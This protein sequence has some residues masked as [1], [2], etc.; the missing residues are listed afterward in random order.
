MRQYTVWRASER[1]VESLITSERAVTTDRCTFAVYVGGRS[2]LDEVNVAVREAWAELLA[3]KDK[4]A[5]IARTLGIPP[6]D[7]TETNASIR[8]EPTK[9]GLSGGEIATALALW[10]VTEVVVG[11]AKDLMKDA[12]K[13]KVR[14]VWKSHVLPLVREKLTRHN[15]IGEE[16]K[17]K[18]ART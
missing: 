17:E 5:D 16:E 9:S 8:A 7:L 2:S 13:Q 15:A 6:D 1:V 14:E 18:P 4:R 3:D 12:L 11:T 10:Y